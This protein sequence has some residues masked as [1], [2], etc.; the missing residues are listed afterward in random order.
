MR[1]NAI[2]NRGSAVSAT[3]SGCGSSELVD[4]SHTDQ[5]TAARSTTAGS[6][7]CSSRW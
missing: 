5:A 3:R 4:P 2:A 1:A 7:E 6:G